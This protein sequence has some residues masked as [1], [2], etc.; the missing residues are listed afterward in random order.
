[1]HILNFSFNS[2]TVPKQWLN[3]V[4]VWSGVM[5]VEL[6]CQV[7]SFLKH[8]FKCVFVANYIQQRQLQMMPTRTYF[9]FYG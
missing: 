1:M 8:A 6:K 7:N 3:A 5:S 2:D 4:P 9:V